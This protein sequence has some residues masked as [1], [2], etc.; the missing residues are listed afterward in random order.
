MN[1]ILTIFLVTYNHEKTIGDTFRGII[2]Q[3]TKYSFVVKILEDHSTDRTLDVC[4]EN[5]RKYPEIFQL[6]AQQKNT[7][8]AHIRSALENEIQTPYFTIIEGDDYWINEKHIDNAISFLE[9][10]REY[11]MYAC[12]VFHSS[13]NEVKDS[14]EVQNLDKEK[15]GHN[16]SLDNYIYLQ[17]SGR[18]YRHIF[19]INDMPINT[20]ER[21]IYLYYLYLDKGKC[22]FDHN[23]SSVYRISSSGVWNS[24]SKKE[25]K[26]C[27]FEVV[28]IGT[29]LLNYR[30]PEFFVKILP[31]C[32][33]KKASRIIGCRMVV[34]LLV[35]YFSI[36][37]LGKNIIR[38]LK[39]DIMNND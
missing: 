23:V 19:N 13:D 1:P 7:K 30:H 38:R 12:N 29:K 6:F 39:Q 24:L 18:V 4:Q 22:F 3:K 26:D 25:K 9:H 28:F 34:Y 33:L 2:N 5:I 32:I 8:G 21:D 11:N 35:F 16:I 14:L 17:T 20:I 31:K 37:I 36:K 10:N 27:S 15:I